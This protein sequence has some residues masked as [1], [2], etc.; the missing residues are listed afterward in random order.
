MLALTPLVEHIHHQ[1]TPKSRVLETLRKL[2]EEAKRMNTGEMDLSQNKT[3]GVRRLTVRRNN[4]TESTREN[5]T[6]TKPTRRW[7]TSSMWM[8]LNSVQ[9]RMGDVDRELLLN[10][11]RTRFDYYCDNRVEF[12]L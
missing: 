7:Q 9:R 11:Q 8:V 6:S 10:T 5:E 4:N 3:V 12:S 2:S 1:A